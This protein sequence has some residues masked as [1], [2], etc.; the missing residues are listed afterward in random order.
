MPLHSLKNSILE[1]VLHR[2]KNKQ[3]GLK[4]VKPPNHYRTHHFD[5][6]AF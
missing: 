2:Q 3:W 4:G 1:F 5:L 6:F